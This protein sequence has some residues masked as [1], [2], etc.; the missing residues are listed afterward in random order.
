M[1]EKQFEKVSNWIRGNETRLKIF[2]ALYKSM[3]IIIAC[4][5]VIAVG[6]MI[7]M[8][9]MAVVVRIISVPVVTLVIC[10]VLRK[11]V[12]EDRPYVAYNFEPIIKKDKTGES[13]PSR[14]MVSAA[15]IAMSALY[16]NTTFGIVMMVIALLCGVIRPLAGVHYIHD[17]ISGFIMGIAC[18]IIGFYVI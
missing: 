14:H 18:G 10:T 8:R 16:V 15:I 3:P 17:I 11:L 6:Y 12:N 9:E 1:N 7:I 2:L 13:F 4:G 5:Y